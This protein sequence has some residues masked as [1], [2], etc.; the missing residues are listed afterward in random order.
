MA[1][2]A[3]K[4]NDFPKYKLKVKL[5]ENALLEKLPGSD[6]VTNINLL[7]LLNSFASGSIINAT[8]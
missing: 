1:V 3:P 5:G 7:I 8:V 2:H 4:A 6:D